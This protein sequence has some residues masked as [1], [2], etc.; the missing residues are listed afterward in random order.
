MAVQNL[1]ATP[2][3]DAQGNVTWTLCNGKCGSQGGYPVS[4]VPKNAAATTFTVTIKDTNKTGVVFAGDPM[5]LQPG[6]K[7]P[8]SK[9]F[10]SNGQIPNNKV[11]VLSPTVIKFQ[12]LNK[13]DPH[14]PPLNLA[15][16]LNFVRNGVAVTPIDPIIQN[17][18][19]CMVGTPNEFGGTT[20]SS[21]SLTG[22]LALAFFVGVLATLLVQRVLRRS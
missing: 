11:T 17:G 6:L 1:E 21:A 3:L 22:Y 19:C 18:G 7:C 20:L 8:T 15:Y 16:Q 5:W 13:N 9:I 14:S 2:T 4:T 10:D 12:D